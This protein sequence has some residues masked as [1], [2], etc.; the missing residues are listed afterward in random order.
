MDR[1]TNNRGGRAMT[2]QGSVLSEKLL[3]SAINEQ[4]SE[5]LGVLCRE[6]NK[7]TKDMSKPDAKQ[8]QLML[9]DMLKNATNV[10]Y[11]K[12]QMRI[13]RPDSQPD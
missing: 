2:Q 6:L 3:Q 12:M 8:A 1:I 5:K 13:E 4:V 7:F 9:L 11:A 10:F